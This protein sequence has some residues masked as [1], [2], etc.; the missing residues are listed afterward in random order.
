[1]TVTAASTNQLGIVITTLTTETRAS[2]RREIY[3]LA[4]SVINSVTWPGET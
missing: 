1:M 3:G 2:L 4:D